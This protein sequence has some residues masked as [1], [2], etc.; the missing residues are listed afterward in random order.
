MCIRDSYFTKSRENFTNAFTSL[1]IFTATYFSASIVRLL[2]LLSPAVAVTAS[3]GLIEIL[4]RL[5][6]AGAT[7]ERRRT[8]GPQTSYR[9]VTLLV[10]IILILVFSPS[11]LASKI[12]LNSHQ[13]PLIL[14]SSIPVVRYNYE[15]MDWLSALGW[16]SEN[17][18]RDA[19]IATWWDYGYWISVNTDR[20]TTCDNATI[21]TKQI[22]KIATAF[23][24]DEATALKIFREL[25]VSYVVVFEPLQSLQLSNGLT[26]WF[27]MMHP[28]L[29]GDMAKSPQMLKWIGRDAREYIYGYNN[30]SFAYIQQQ[31]GRT[32]YL[33]LPANTPQALNA[34]LYKMI[35]AKNYKQQVFVFDSFL[36]M[37][38]G[39]PGYHGPSYTIPQLE[40]F[41]L[42][43]VSEPNGWVKIFRVKG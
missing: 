28:A 34:T 41:E 42:V 12:P 40:H 27:T 33:I 38:G 30:G 8:R 25:N 14:T 16:I 3:L 15:Y 13:P 26:V 5:A 7:L 43:Y 10:A 2:L 17:I 29:G 19:T 9:L 4:D 23:M 24:S 20:K 21:D 22:Q 39:L 32:I 31:G 18:P 1:F 11:I 35:Y 6:E 36:Q 37:L